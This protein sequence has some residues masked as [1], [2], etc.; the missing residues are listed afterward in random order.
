MKKVKQLSCAV[1]ILLLC[2][3]FGACAIEDNGTSQP[4][5]NEY[6]QVQKPDNIP[7]EGWH[8]MMLWYTDTFASTEDGL[9][10]LNNSCLCF[11]DT[12]TG[13]ST[14]LCSKAGCR[15]G[16]GDARTCDA[17]V[18]GMST[19]LF[20]CNGRIYYD[21]YDDYGLQLYSRNADGTGQKKE[22]TLCAQH[23]TKNTSVGISNL[24][25]A[26]NY[27]YYSVVVDGITEQEDGSINSETIYTALVRYDLNTGTEEELFRSEEETAFILGTTD[28]MVLLYMRYRPTT[29]DMQRPDYIEYMKQYPGY[30]RLW[31]EKAGGVSLLCEADADKCAQYIGIANGNIYH[32]SS[33]EEKTLYAYDLASGS[34][35]KSDLPQ[36]VT[37]IWNKEYAAVKLDGYYDLVSGEYFANDYGT[38][39]LPSGIDDFGASLTIVDTGLVWCE[40]YSKDSKGVYDQYA[41][42]P[43]ER[44][45]DGMQLSDRMVFIYQDDDGSKLVQPES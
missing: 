6:T 33:G 2:F 24:S 4:S 15:H 3:S 19:M 17:Y 5:T 30:I 8:P 37:R 41:Y 27:L 44:L 18:P 23:A 29:A 22:A 13:Y 11:L 21:I 36:D 28:D 42:V 12:K 25:V 10:F 39:T 43:F 16:E 14:Y 40:F 26:D 45:A 38:M 31:S 35:G 7:T 1:L 20:F 9:F 32:R 34:F